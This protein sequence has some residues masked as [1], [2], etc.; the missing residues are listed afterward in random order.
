MDYMTINE[1]LKELRIEN[2]LTQKQLADKIGLGQ[3]TVASHEKSHTP[4]LDNLVAYA[5]FFECSLDY[6]AGREEAPLPYALS[7]QERE[8][9]QAFRALRPSAKKFALAQMRLLSESEINR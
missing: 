7:E 3:T 5:D 8:L 2:G 1:R 9:V 6:L 4:T